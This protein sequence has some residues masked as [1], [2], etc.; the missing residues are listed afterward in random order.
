VSGSSSLRRRLVLAIAL[1]DTTF[2][3]SSVRGEVCWVGRC[4]HCNSKLVVPEQGL[5]AS[6]VTVEHIVPVAHGGQNELTNVGLACARCNHEKGR[7]HDVKRLDDPQRLAL[8]RALIERRA[9]RLREPPHGT[10]HL[11]AKPYATM[12]VGDRASEGVDSSGASEESPS[13]G[14]RPHRRGRRPP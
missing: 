10:E 11:L 9:A 7:R 14:K 12:A 5:P 2:V 4:L 1:T 6:S 8:E 3:R 13:H